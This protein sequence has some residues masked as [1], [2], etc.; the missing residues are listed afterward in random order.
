MRVIKKSEQERDN[1]RVTRLLESPVICGIQRVNNAD[2]FKQIISSSVWD[3]NQHITMKNKD[4]LVNML[5]YE[6]TNEL[7]RGKVD[8]IWEGL[9]VMGFDKYFRYPA[10]EIYF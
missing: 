4:I 1:R 6:K 2:G 7:R 5:L 9:N 3:S 10:T 8:A